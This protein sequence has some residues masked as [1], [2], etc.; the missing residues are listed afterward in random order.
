MKS[1]YKE[2]ICD[3]LYT[4]VC[5]GGFCEDFMAKSDRAAKIY[6]SKGLSFGCGHLTLYSN[7]DFNGDRMEV[8][9]REFWQSLNRFGW[10][11]WK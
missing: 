6:A 11:R 5:S 1:Q 3:T 9:T 2:E 8:G 10:E 7:R 4:I